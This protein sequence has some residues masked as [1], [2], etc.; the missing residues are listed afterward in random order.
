MCALTVCMLTSYSKGAGALDFERGGSNTILPNKWQTDDAMDRGSW[1]WVNPP[2]LKN[3][4]ELIDELVGQ[5]VYP[6]YWVEIH[7]HLGSANT[8]L[9][10]VDRYRE[11][12]WQPAARYPATRRRFDRPK[13]P[14]HLVRDWRLAGGQWSGN[15][16]NQAVVQRN[17]RRGPDQDF[18]RWGAY[19]GGL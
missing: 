19:G 9:F 5:C 8:F 3:E 14:S 4:S 1:S 17:L 10:V 18:A 12:K 15:F 6:V 16:R 11:Q 13:G 7:W 2:N